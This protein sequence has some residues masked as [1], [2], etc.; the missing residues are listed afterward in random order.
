MAMATTANASRLRFGSVSSVETN[1]RVDFDELYGRYHRRVRG[2]VRRK[3]ADRHLADDVVQEVFLRLYRSLDTVDPGRDLWP[4][5]AR[6]AD[7][8]AVDA[9]RRRRPTEEMREA[10]VD[11]LSALV[12]PV[13]DPAERYTARE[14]QDG[15]ASA[16]TAVCSRQRRMLML[17]E[18]EGWAYEDI[19]EF[20]GITLD[21]LKSALKRARKTFRDAYSAL[22]EER[23][24]WGAVLAPAYGVG[25]RLRSAM[26]RAEVQLATP[27][28]S[29]SSSL[30]ANVASLMVAAGIATAAMSGAGTPL[31]PSLAGANGPH[32]A[33]T[34]AVAGADSAITPSVPTDVSAPAVDGR[35]VSLRMG[36]DQLTG[37]QPAAATPGTDVV[38]DDEH[39]GLIASAS[40]TIGGLPDSSPGVEAAVDCR[41]QYTSDLCDATR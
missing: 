27:L 7:N 1:K 40:A 26:S 24:L 8:A 22:A 30:S 35:R 28:A 36:S 37:S 38:Q 9:L 32:P 2:F 5:L 18:A 41:D 10:I 21:A 39:L 13:D 20:E 14:R 16:M 12:R 31:S 34:F 6:V 11:G 4:W 23:G 17:R 3:I 15:I 19:A 25:R 33:P 29:L